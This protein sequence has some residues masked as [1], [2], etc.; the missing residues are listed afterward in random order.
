MYL[1]PGPTRTKAESMSKFTNDVITNTGPW[2][3]ALE[4]VSLSL[5]L[6]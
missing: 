3:L 6:G 5:S 2:A 4:L 1:H